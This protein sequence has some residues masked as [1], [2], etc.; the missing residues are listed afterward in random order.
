MLHRRLDHVEAIEH[1][2]DVFRADVLL[3]FPEDRSAVF[4][5]F[6]PRA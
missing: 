6:P 5:T 1:L 3:G 4:S 2:I